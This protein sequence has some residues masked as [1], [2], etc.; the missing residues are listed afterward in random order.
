MTVRSRPG[1][2]AALCVAPSVLRRLVRDG[3]LDALR[4]G[5]WYILDGAVPAPRCAVCDGLIRGRGATALYCGP[6][7]A[8]KRRERA[9]VWRPRCPS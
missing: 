4:H 3:A 6:C 2:A 1:A 5:D 8:G 9:R 7:A